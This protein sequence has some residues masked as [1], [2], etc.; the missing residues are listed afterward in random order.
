[1]KLRSASNTNS[2]C[3]LTSGPK[4]TL[5]ASTAHAGVNW[6]PPAQLTFLLVLC[7][8][9]TPPGSTEV[10]LKID[11][12]LTPDSFDDQYQSCSKQV[13][14][15][16]SQG[17]YF[18]KEIDA[19]KN[20][21][22]VWQ[23]NHLT[24]LSQVKT[25]PK[26]M[27]TMHAV[28]VLVYTFDHSVRSD[29]SKAM[30]SAARSP[31]QYKQSFHFKYL[32]YYLTSAIQLL[33]K[34]TKNGTLCYEVHHGIQDAHFKANIG[35]TI[36]FGQFLFTSQLREEM[37]KFGN[38]TLFTIYTCLGAP[39]QQLSLKKKVLIPPYEL[40]E[41]VNKSYSPKGDW[42][43]L[44]SVGNLS[45]YNCQLLKASSK[46]CIPSPMFI[47]FL[48]IL[49]SVVILPNTTCNGIQWLLFKET[50]EIFCWLFLSAEAEIQSF[51]HATE[52]MG[53]R[54]WWK[55]TSL[56]SQP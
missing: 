55:E 56:F 38:Q 2:R 48:S 46:K 18:T 32:H 29:F 13:M 54:S 11:L 1:M 44:R 28:T 31:K 37:Q 8:L 17:D 22:R 40:F 23:K 3:P 20:Y 24:W 35:A 50:I 26:D 53:D 36:R 27:T 21:S 41:V 16:L 12:D 15:E 45:T 30:A 6:L 33:R 7:A 49:V 52:D 47:A 34:A 39:V 9:Q 14:E 25:L 19:H 4:R 51:P 5:V 10:A 43:Y 42:L